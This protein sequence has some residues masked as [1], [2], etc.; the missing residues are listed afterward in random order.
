VWYDDRR[1]GR[2]RCRA[3]SRSCGVTE[4]ATSGPS[5]GGAGQHQERR[6]GRRAAGIES[7]IGAIGHKFGFAMQGREEREKEKGQFLNPHRFVG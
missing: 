5:E 4:Q 6:R 1:R 2:P 7:G 3:A